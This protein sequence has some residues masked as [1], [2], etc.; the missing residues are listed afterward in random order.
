PPNKNEREQRCCGE[1]QSPGAS[2]AHWSV[3]IGVALPALSASH[4][5][6]EIMCVRGDERMILRRACVLFDNACAASCQNKRRRNQYGCDAS[7]GNQ[8]QTATLSDRQNQN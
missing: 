7:S 2:E 4:E 8:S 3:L 6:P 1:N 5:P